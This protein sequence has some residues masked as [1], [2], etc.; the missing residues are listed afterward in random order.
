VICHDPVIADLDIAR[1][2]A[3]SLGMP[4]LEEVLQRFCPRAFLDIELKVT[5]L[6]TLLIKA[7]RK[8]PPQ[9][10][11]VVSS[12]LPEVLNA[13]QDL[14]ASILLGF[15]CDR[16]NQVPPPAL[17]IAWVIPNVKLTSRELVD[18]FHA[19][20]R[21]IMVWT[22]N[23]AAKMHQLAAWGVDAIISDETQLLVQSVR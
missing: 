4:V 8:Y 10:G 14:D 23:D 13:V 1:T 9:K 11:Y 21:K 7:L 16:K 22:V 20:A 5:G 3:K 2:P 12:F 15:L 18:E 19:S 6:E 17:P